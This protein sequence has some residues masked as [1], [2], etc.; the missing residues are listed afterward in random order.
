[1]WVY[2]LWIAKTY[3]ANL[4]VRDVSLSLNMTRNG[5]ITTEKGKWNARYKALQKGN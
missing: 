4:S 2:L 1:M 3:L 5:N